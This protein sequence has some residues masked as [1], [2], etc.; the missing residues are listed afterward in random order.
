MIRFITIL[1]AAVVF[2]G[3][4]SADTLDAYIKAR[5]QYGINTATTSLAL[6]TLVGGAVME[7]KGQVRGTFTMDGKTSLLLE[8]PGANPVIVKG[9]EMPP[10][11]KFPQAHARIL[12][13]ASR[14]T[15]FSSLDAS[16]IAFVE[17]G[18]IAEWERGVAASAARAP[19]T[20]AKL[21]KASKDGNV[22]EWNLQPNEAVPIYANFIR[23]YN[24]RLSVAKATEI[25]T[26]IVGFSVQYGVDARLITAMVL[27][28]S[29]FNPS[30]RSHVG[31]MGLGQLMPGTAK[32]L[33]VR[34]AYDTNENLYG[35][36]RLIR[37]HL[38]KYSDSNIG[39]GKYDELVLALAA[40]NAGGG[41][42]K[43]HNGVP[44]YKE[45]QNYIKKVTT[46]Y[47]RLR[48]G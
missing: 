29:G 39:G 41:A 1:F 18:A 35:T 11:I 27:V 43:R 10:W 47:N 42:V 17:E 19:K 38:D 2:G 30:A 40:Y 9:G 33:G 15:E 16:V 25:A 45:T 5:K 34:D 7:V 3:T 14:A 24:P 36:V 28:E 26:A 31:A 23:G 46:W 4:A 32:G 21:P 22:R 12:V 44:P 8:V 13:R 48:G 37:G 20:A 6:D